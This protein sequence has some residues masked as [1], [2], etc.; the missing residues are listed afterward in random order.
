MSYRPNND[1]ISI[2]CARRVKIIDD[3]GRVLM[4]GNPID[5]KKEFHGMHPKRGFYKLDREREQKFFDRLQD[6]ANKGLVFT[7]NE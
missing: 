6:R 2:M 1:L 7:T 5:V 4:E 3:S